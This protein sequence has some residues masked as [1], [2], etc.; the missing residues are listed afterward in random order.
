MSCVKRGDAGGRSCRISARGFS[1]IELLVAISVIAILS[2]LALQVYLGVRERSENV[3]CI[4]NLKTTGLAILIHAG[5][6]GGE[7]V[8]ALYEP[9]SSPVPN[10]DPSA[11]GHGANRVWVQR[12]LNE[13]YLSPDLSESVCPAF[14]PFTYTRSNRR[15]AMHTYGLRQWSDSDALGTKRNDPAY[16]AARVENPS[17]YALLMDSYSRPENAQIYYIR[18]HYSGTN[19]R[20]H[21]RHKGKANIFF[22]DGSVRSLTAE[23]VKDLND[24]WGDNA[25]ITMEETPL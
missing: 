15:R 20:I 24:G 10:P 5:D 14:T 1:L 23:D 12:L 6:H 9:A 22:A 25:T 4:A 2:A 3:R 8:T 21:L 11:P 19:I 13:G 18:P 7:S 16:T 17:N